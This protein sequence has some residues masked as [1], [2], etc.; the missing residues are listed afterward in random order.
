LPRKSAESLEEGVICTLAQCIGAALIEFETALIEDNMSRM[1]KKGKEKK[2][3]T[4]KTDIQ[5]ILLLIMLAIS[6]TM[7]MITSCA[8]KKAILEHPQIE[9]DFS[10]PDTNN[11]VEKYRV[12][13]N[14]IYE[15]SEPDFRP[16]MET[17]YFEFDCHELDQK[18]IQTIENI[19]FVAGSDNLIT[20]TITGATCEI[21]EDDYNLKLGL[22]RGHSAKKYLIGNCGLKNNIY[23][24][25][26]G[27]K[28]PVTKNKNDYHLNRRCEIRIEK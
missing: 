23:V 1:D 15:N 2:V 16:Y 4:G 25:S 3:N 12:E 19:A 27:E 17:I 20:L 28:C 24:S 5:I 13:E 8:G 22:R 14:L 26:C 21:G 7:M 18:A 6:G 9:Y 10:W 11:T